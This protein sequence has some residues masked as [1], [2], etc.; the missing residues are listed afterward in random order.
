[1]DEE[2]DLAV[3]R[4]GAFQASF[5]FFPEVNSKAISHHVVIFAANEVG[6]GLGIPR[7]V[8]DAAVGCGHDCARGQDQNQKRE[9][10]L[11]CSQY[12]FIPPN[13]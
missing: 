6:A 2:C 4:E 3:V 12:H 1:M 5:V 9:S 10:M 11:H 8:L 7:C 13:E